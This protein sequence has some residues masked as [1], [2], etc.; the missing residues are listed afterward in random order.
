VDV[1][2]T[3]AAAP[4]TAAHESTQ[5]IPA[6][7]VLD[8]LPVM[9]FS[10]TSPIKPEPEPARLD[11]PDL[12]VSENSLNFDLPAADAPAPAV[13]APA[14]APAAADSGMLEFDLGGL[15]LDLPGSAASTADASDSTSSGMSTTGLEMPSLTATIRWPPSSPWRRNS[16]PSA[17]PTAPAAWPRKSSPKHPAT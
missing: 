3:F 12:T 15:S 7:P 4:A 13:A 10:A 17:T 5:A 16:T 8:P 9:D 6:Q 1:S 14:P 2:P 11:A